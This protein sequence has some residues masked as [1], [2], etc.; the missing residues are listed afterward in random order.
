MLYLFSPFDKGDNLDVGWYRSAFLHM[1]TNRASAQ[2]NSSS[3][4]APWD[5]N[6]ILIGEYCSNSGASWSLTWV[7]KASGIRGLLA[8]ADGLFVSSEDGVIGFQFA[9]LNAKKVTLITRPDC[10]GL[11]GYR[12]KKIFQVMQGLEIYLEIVRAENYLVKSRLVS[13]EDQTLWTVE[14]AP[15]MVWKGEEVQIAEWRSVA[16]GSE[17]AHLSSV[18]LPDTPALPT[19]EPGEPGSGLIPSLSGIGDVGVEFL[20]IDR[21]S[22]PDAGLFAGLD[23]GRLGA[24]I[25]RLEK[26]DAAVNFVLTC[27]F[28]WEESEAMREALLTR[29]DVLAKEVE[30][31]TVKTK[32]FTEEGAIEIVLS[33]GR[34]LDDSDSDSGFRITEV[35]VT[36]L[37]QEKHICFEIELPEGVLERETTLI[38][39]QGY[40]ARYTKQFVDLVLARYGQVAAQA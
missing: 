28:P 39:R 22:Q 25:R 26:L 9:S 33:D 13:S 27:P 16:Q 20:R 24:R 15:F 6:A 17:T 7:R 21:Y 3:K 19:V 18:G 37:F 12:K 23:I 14:Y 5:G 8:A 31:P 34:T 32:G 11:R 38:L 30:K 1:A 4:K 36:K 40:T 10:K 2:A 35:K 29:Y